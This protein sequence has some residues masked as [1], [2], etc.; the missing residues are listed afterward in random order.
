M[1]LHEQRMQ[2]TRSGKE[3]RMRWCSPPLLNATVST[4]VVNHHREENI[5]SY[6]A[7]LLCDATVDT[8]LVRVVASWRWRVACKM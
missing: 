7:V 8:L 1:R 6:V 3:C 2:D 5:G 4:S